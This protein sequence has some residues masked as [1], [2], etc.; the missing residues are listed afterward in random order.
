MMVTWP[1]PILRSSPSQI[2]Y[3]S[4][5]AFSKIEILDVSYSVYKAGIY[6]GLSAEI[7]M[8]G[9]PIKG[10]FRGFSIYMYR[11]PPIVE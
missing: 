10:W 11:P 4:I 6:K 5:F 2:L 9:M 7:H 1:D 3:I 8:P